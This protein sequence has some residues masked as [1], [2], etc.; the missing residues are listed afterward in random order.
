MTKRISVLLAED[1]PLVLAALAGLVRS[2]RGLELVEA[3]SDGLAAFAALGAGSP[4]VA[5]VDVNMPGLSGL[6]FLEEVR[7]RGLLVKVALF[8]AEISDAQTYDAVAG[9]VDG[10]VLKSSA[11]ETLIACIRAIASGERYLSEAAMAAVARQQALQER[12]RLALAPLSARER[13]IATMAAGQASNREIADALDITEGTVK[14]HLHSIFAK[15]GATG[16]ASLRAL[17]S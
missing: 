6:Q 15:L 12:R 2:A 14:V 7:S 4:D 9:G 16:R 13:D 11:P 5:V 1:H 8:T 3:C 17:L 10:I